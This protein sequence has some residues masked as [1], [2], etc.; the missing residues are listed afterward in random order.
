M[1]L[2]HS[3]YLLS[4]EWCFANLCTIMCTNL[5]LKLVSNDKIKIICILKNSLLL[6]DCLVLQKK[7]ELEAT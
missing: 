3:K 4:D 2:G 1:E 6:Y 7:L 5:V